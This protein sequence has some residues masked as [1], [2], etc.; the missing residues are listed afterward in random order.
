[1]PEVT[2]IIHRITYESNTDVIESL[3]KAFGNQF[4]LLK[5]LQAEEAKLNQLIASTGKQEV[6]QQQALNIALTRT[7]SQIDQVTT[8]LGREFVANEKLSQSFAKSTANTKNLGFAFSQVLREAPAFTYSI[9]TGLLGISNNIPILL[10]RL[11]EARAS[12]TSTAGIFKALGSSIFGLTGIV[13]LAVSAFTIFGDKIFKSGEA[14]KEANDEYQNFLKTLNQNTQAGIDTSNQQINRLN[15]LVAIIRDTTIAEEQRAK[16]LRELQKEYPN[17]LKNV[18]AEGVLQGKAAKS[19]DAVTAAINARE[20]AAAKSKNLILFQQQ[21]RQ[22]LSKLTDAQVKAAKASENYQAI[23]AKYEGKPVGPGTTAAIG[24]FRQLAEKADAEL[25]VA[26][27]RLESRRKLIQK[28]Q[29]EITGALLGAQDLTV[30]GEDR[31][32]KTILKKAKE[33]AEEADPALKQVKFDIEEIVKLLQSL[34]VIPIKLPFGTI[35]AKNPLAPDPDAD[36]KSQEALEKQIGY[37]QDAANAIIGTFQM[38][39]DAKIQALDFELEVTQSRIIAATELAKRGNG[40]VL[41]DELNNLNKLSEEREKLANRQLAINSLLQASG[42]ALAA[43]QA[44]QTVTN[45]GTTGDPY[46]IPIRI[47]AAVAA[48]ASGVALVTGIV[49]AA[50]GFKDGVIDLDGPGTSKSDSIAARLSKGE[51]VITAEKTQRYRP[52]LEAIHA[53]TFERSFP[54]YNNYAS[55]TEMKGVE[56]KLDRLIEL[57]MGGGT[58]VKNMV[59]GGDLVTVTQ[60]HTLRQQNRWK[61]G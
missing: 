59:S 25:Q 11:K 12:G 17:Q 32:K 33:D 44:I 19:I 28:T 41:E 55:R 61:R 48:L 40:E 30:E 5:D 24:A 53:G 31:G 37:Y 43:V 18:T 2:D 7:K 34:D 54:T 20:Q 23:L 35:D 60:K 16:A 4:K 47:A 6:A 52:V 15:S 50:R 39:N 49:S 51:S 45:A 8:A 22:E 57:N 10:D 21:E 29:Q 27:T 13:T 56:R 9:Q 3:N 14:A 38:I 36:K 58:E 1:M 46:T 26:N 42:A